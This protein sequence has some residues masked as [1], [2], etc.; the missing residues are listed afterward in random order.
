MTLTRSQR[1][2]LTKVA[3]Q[4]A[5]RVEEA[6]PTKKRGTKSNGKSQSTSTTKAPPSPVASS[7]KSPDFSGHSIEPVIT[8]SKSCFA[9]KRNCND[10]FIE[11]M[12]RYCK[13]HVG[14]WS[15]S[16]WIAVLGSMSNHLETQN[17]GRLATM[18]L[19]ELLV[20]LVGR[21]MAESSAVNV[22][23]RIGMSGHEYLDRVLESVF[24][25]RK[26]PLILSLIFRVLD[27]IGLREGTGFVVDIL[28][29][30]ILSAE[31][32]KFSA[33]FVS[34]LGNNFRET[35]SIEAFFMIQV[36]VVHI[37]RELVCQRDIQTSWPREIMIS[38]VGKFAQV[39]TDIVNR[40]SDSNSCL[41]PAHLFPLNDRAK[42]IK[43][44]GLGD[45]IASK[46]IRP[47]RKDT[48]FFLE[49]NKLFECE[50]CKNFFRQ[51]CDNCA[52]CPIEN[53]CWGCGY[54]LVAS[55][56]EG[57]SVVNKTTNENLVAFF[58]PLSQLKS[59]DE[60]H[61]ALLYALDVSK[62]DLGL[63]RETL[64]STVLID[65]TVSGT[66]APPFAPSS[67]FTGEILFKLLI[68][69]KMSFLSDLIFKSLI[70]LLADPSSAT[71]A[72]RELKNLSLSSIANTAG[73]SELVLQQIR[74]AK[75]VKSLN[76]LLGYLEHMASSWKING[77]EILEIFHIHRPIIT[78]N[79]KKLIVRI[80]VTGSNWTTSDSCEMFLDH[81][82][83][84]LDVDWQD[85]FDQFVEC[86]WG[87][88]GFDVS[89]WSLILPVIAN[90]C[91]VRDRLGEALSSHQR[92]EIVS[93]LI[94]RRNGFDTVEYLL[95]SGKRF[96]GNVEDFSSI[97]HELM[98]D[99]L[100]SD[101]LTSSLVNSLSRAIEATDSSRFT[102]N[103]MYSRI[104]AKLRREIFLSKQLSVVGGG[105]KLLVVMTKHFQFSTDLILEV[106]RICLNTLTRSSLDNEPAAVIRASVI[107]SSLLS[108]M[109]SGLVGSETVSDW[110]DG[111]LK[112]YR[113]LPKTVGLSVVSEMLCNTS[114]REFLLSNIDKNFFET[115]IRE[116]P[117]A[118]I[119]AVRTVL[120]SALSANAEASAEQPEM[121][122]RSLS[123]RPDQGV[124]CRSLAPLFPYI[125]DALLSSES[126][127]ETIHNSIRAVNAFVTLGIVNPRSVPSL[128]MARYILSCD[129]RDGESGLL[130]TQDLN[131]CA[132]A[133][134][135]PIDSQLIRFTLSSMFST[136]FE[137]FSSSGIVSEIYRTVE[138]C[139]PI[140]SNSTKRLVSKE[141]SRFC[142]EYC[143]EELMKNCD[144][145]NETKSVFLSC[146]LV[147]GAVYV[148]SVESV[149]S[150]LSNA[151]GLSDDEKTAA[152]DSL[153]ALKFALAN[154]ADAQKERMTD[155]FGWVE[156]RV[157]QFRKKELG[158]INEL[159]IDQ[160][161]VV[162]SRKRTRQSIGTKGTKRRKKNLNC[163]DEFTS[164]DSSS[165][166]E[167]SVDN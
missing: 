23:A 160:Q 68:R 70:P 53:C 86:L 110:S 11:E 133:K 84:E 13:A 135:S 130:N 106:G 17:Y 101:T 4:P 69:E 108:K 59:K 140:E 19:I 157:A 154:L 113:E 158:A 6:K 94:H 144:S 71:A 73:M 80:F 74:E 150:R 85:M 123:D 103:E 92:S 76:A 16:E 8:Y 66:S 90:N 128:L 24:E 96:Q 44:C 72:S 26:I 142:V 12:I 51:S 25:C 119:A 61:F 118:T 89:V 18:Y 111:L 54:R 75:D 39:F 55:G 134:V 36:C 3:Q 126:I 64:M 29:K 156:D 107:L 104:F 35:F 56:G 52:S 145:Q 148:G 139:F 122:A 1:R 83:S 28:S 5:A 38:L 42:D 105:A 57:D 50:F 117:D 129:D 33:K 98:H 77:N 97:V 151:V 14:R 120:E 99:V 162:L 124:H 121:N 58:L 7:D 138:L 81:L 95:E 164:G 155:R 79:T 63:D 82:S 43:Y 49:S 46:L 115:S 41:L 15:E 67:S 9:D 20:D 112:V 132:I 31:D 88:V 167:E 109:N 48:A 21:D 37:V 114:I 161:E 62:I 127:P 152:G 165:D 149:T 137:K 93:G 78:G 10:D 166:H 47:Q 116:C 22:L 136:I 40:F 60:K 131:I 34:E 102:P 2:E 143:L 100:S 141:G 45:C 147:I 87:R 159:V 146:V 125:R 30:H 27:R 91:L 65:A 153:F 32:S 163:S